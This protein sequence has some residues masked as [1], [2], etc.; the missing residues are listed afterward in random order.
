MVADFRLWG[1]HFFGNVGGGLLV[2]G[3]GDGGE[4]KD[5]SDV[6]GSEEFGWG[7]AG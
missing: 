3:L 4:F 2:G 1:K 7:K 6:T 5:V